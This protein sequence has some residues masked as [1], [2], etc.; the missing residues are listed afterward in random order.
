MTEAYSTD[1]G[2]VEVADVGL[3]AIEKSY[4]TVEAIRG[5]DL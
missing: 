4:G 5:V 3:R 2:E 1:K